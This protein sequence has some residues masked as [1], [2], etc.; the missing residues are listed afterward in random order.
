MEMVSGP[1][2]LKNSRLAGAIRMAQ[3]CGREVAEK[4]AAA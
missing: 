3:N 4:I 2:R 1:L